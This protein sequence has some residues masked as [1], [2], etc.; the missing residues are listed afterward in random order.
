MLKVESEL[1]IVAAE[2]MA[3]DELN[4]PDKPLAELLEKQDDEKRQESK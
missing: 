2:A 4:L 3:A 1:K